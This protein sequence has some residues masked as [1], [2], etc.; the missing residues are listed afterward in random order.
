MHKPQCQRCQQG[1]QHW[2]QRQWNCVIR[3]LHIP[4]WGNVS[5]DLQE[6]T[7]KK[8][9]MVLIFSVVTHG[10]HPFSQSVVPLPL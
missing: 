4:H 9:V 7:D 8:K 5:H 6:N 2:Q 1:Q 10:A 3:I